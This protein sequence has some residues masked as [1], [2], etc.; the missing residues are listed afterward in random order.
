MGAFIESGLQD[1]RYT[2]PAS[3]IGNPDEAIEAYKRGLVRDKMPT[4]Q[5]GAKQAP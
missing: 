4:L 5:K 2:M 3:Y 1:K